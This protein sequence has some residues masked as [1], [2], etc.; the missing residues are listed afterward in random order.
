MKNTSILDSVNIFQ[1]TDSVVTL[2]T[3]NTCPLIGRPWGMTFWTPQTGEGRW[4]Y[5]RRRSQPGGKMQGFRATHQCS[6]WIGDY[7]QFTILPLVGETFENA[8]KRASSFR[9]QDEHGRPDYYRVYLNRYRT[10]VELTATPRCGM[11]RSYF[12][13]TDRA[14][15]LFSLFTDE[16]TVT[17]SD[18][19]H[20]VSGYSMSHDSGGCPENL[21]CYF[22]AHMDKP[23]NN[24]EEE[25]SGRGLVAR[26]SAAPNEPV[27]L[28]IG[29]SYISPE[30]AECNLNREIGSRSFEQV[31][32]ESEEVWERQISRI[33]LEGGT[34]E[35]QRTFYSCLYRTMLY[36]RV[37]HEFDAS[38]KRI[39]FSPYD[40][41][42]H[43][44]TLYADNGFWDT[45]RTVYSFYSI[46]FPEQ[47]SEILRGWLT[48]F[49]E[50]GWF[51]RWSAPGYKSSMVGTHLAAVMADAITK[52]IGGFDWGQ[53]YEGMRK[54]AT[55]PGDEEGRWGRPGL[56]FYIQHG[57]LPCDEEPDGVAGTLDYAYSDWCC[58]QVARILQKPE[59]ERTFRTRAENWKNLFDPSTGFMRPRLSDG[60][61]LTPFDLFRWG[62]PYREGGPWQYRFHV[63]HDPHGLADALGG[64]ENL[65]NEISRM[66]NTPPH[67]NIGDYPFEIHEMTEMAV[68]EFGQYAHSNQ[69]V[70]AYLWL[71]LLVGHPQVTDDT[72]HRVLTELYSSEGFCGDEDNGEMSAWYIFASLGMFPHCPGDA[73]YSLTPPLFSAATLHCDDG[74]KLRIRR[75]GELSDTGEHR[76]LSHETI[77]K[78]DNSRE[79]QI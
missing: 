16:C 54:D 38:G 53:A 33:Q 51:P 44:G 37:F 17:V 63:P 71:P 5:S 24:V 28:R 48:A 50:G 59:D 62:G 29:T 47:L 61:W 27:T 76:R 49:A 3:G 13:E 45:Y 36:P 6:P 75:T 39:H 12:P 69:P 79:I 25:P 21:A 18:D 56:S 42:I 1:G 78:N 67:F 15:I 55:V 23:M 72:V 64:P 19:G 8:D 70:H 41:R 34:E 43:E 31:R 74:K 65:V 77:V 9:F 52:G 11:I 40:G 14:G 60:S 7:G 22:V 46:L 68:A 66:L 73:A 20:W 58:A 10:T 30:Q 57:Y 26:F 35:Q 32:Q 4:P 2:S